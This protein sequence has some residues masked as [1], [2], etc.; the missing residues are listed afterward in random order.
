MTKDDQILEELKEIKADG[1]ETK[2]AVQNN[3]LALVRVNGDIKLHANQIDRNT[4]DIAKHELD[5]K[6]SDRRLHERDEKID[7][8]VNGMLLKVTGAATAAGAAAGAAIN[9]IVSRL[10]G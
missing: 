2:Q 7:G 9:A 3:G 1:K 5:R 8:K 6:S 4:T 10:P